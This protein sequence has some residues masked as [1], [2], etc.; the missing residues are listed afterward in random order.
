MAVISP[1][2]TIGI[3]GGGQ[4]GRMM[5][6]AA[7]Q[8]GGPEEGRGDDEWLGHRG[9]GDLLSGCGGAQAGQVETADL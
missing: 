7:A 1:G 3:L 2:A 9:V 5:A 8:L 6:S 4:L